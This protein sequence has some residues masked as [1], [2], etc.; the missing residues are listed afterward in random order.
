MA[1]ARYDREEVANVA[2]QKINRIL[3]AKM[4]F[5][6]AEDER[7]EKRVIEEME[8]KWYRPW[9]RSRE[10]AKQTVM[11]ESVFPFF[12]LDLLRRRDYSAELRKAT[13]IAEMAE[14]AQTGIT[15]DQDEASFLYENVKC[16]GTAA[17]DS[18]SEANEGAYPP[19]PPTT[20]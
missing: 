19:L 20:C 2:K 3:E 9:K 11:M 13:R 18:Q 4:K 6:A 1:T 14:H 8:P 7:I 15:L 5:R 17:Q 12:R 10:K 16:G